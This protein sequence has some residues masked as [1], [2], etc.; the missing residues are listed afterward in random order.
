M[1]GSSAFESQTCALIIGAPSIEEYSGF[2]TTDPSKTG[3]SSF[4][5][6]CLSSIKY[7]LSLLLIVPDKSQCLTSTITLLP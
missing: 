3:S 5:T 6:V 4:T 2:K 1:N 7:G